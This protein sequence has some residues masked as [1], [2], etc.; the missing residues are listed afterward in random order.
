MN[1]YTTRVVS[2]VK[3]E[4]VAT[5]NQA[6]TKSN[7]TSVKL[8]NTLNTVEEKTN[9]FLKRLTVVSDMLLDLKTITGDVKNQI[10]IISSGAVLQKTDIE[11]S[12]NAIEVSKDTQTEIP[13]NHEKSVIR[14]ILPFY[15]KDQSG[16]Q[17]S[18]REVFKFNKN[19]SISFSRV[20]YSFSVVLVY[21]YKVFLNS[22]LLD[23]LNTYE[24][25]LP[26]LSSLK[27]LNEDGKEVQVL[28]NNLKSIDLNDKLRLDN[29]YNLTFETVYT[30]QLTIEFSNKSHNS[31]SITSIKSYLNT[32]KS[33]GE[34]IYGPFSTKSSILKASISSSSISDQTEISVSHDMSSWIK[35]DTT[36]S[37][38]L[39]QDKTKVVSFN[40]I[41]DR[42]FKTEEDVKKLYV[43]ISINPLQDTSLN[44]AYKTVKESNLSRTPSTLPKDKYTI[45]EKRERS[46]SYGV[47][48][49]LVASLDLVPTESIDSLG[50]RNQ[51]YSIGFV[52]TPFSCSVA[53]KEQ[54]AYKYVNK[55]LKVD[56]GIIDATYIDP[57]EFNI[58][59]MQILEVKDTY[60]NNSSQNLCIKSNVP[61]GMYK[62]VVGSKTLSLDLTSG[63]I[64][65]SLNL[66]VSVP[67]SDVKILNEINEV[68]FNIQKES[69]NKYTEDEVDYYYLDLSNYLFHTIVISG[70][71]HSVLYP[72]LP[73][74]TDE[75][76]LLNGSLVF[77]DSN[78]YE[79]DIFQ[80]A[81]KEVVYTTHLSYLN[82]N[83]LKREEDDSTTYNF[84]VVKDSRSIIK[85]N[86]VLIKNGSVVITNV[87][88]EDTEQYTPQLTPAVS[89]LNLG[90]D[91]ELVYLS[92]D[93]D[94]PEIYLEI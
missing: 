15:L 54:R 36:T 71:K 90:Q 34:I 42:S 40:T 79:V 85:L 91:Q 25:N 80:L 48:T 94:N 62:I 1:K 7:D 65:N 8:F 3:E 56:S 59:D 37:L 21:P 14:S 27:Y 6:T 53:N 39:S 31:L 26:V 5:V 23:F 84:T 86:H 93:T 2:D 28:V 52:D 74:N 19:F 83:Y 51:L 61:E 16:V 11:V 73:L 69:L 32:Y 60:R 13:F 18:Q 75:F 64:N 9:T 17:I 20:G 29:N 45:Y 88:T 4:L 10:N 43:K 41:N 72:S 76:S 81:K 57:K 58:Y 63:Y 49:N 87:A 67:Y 92:T 55:L 44:T 46:R 35:M 77:S 68:V 38:N 89:Y 66:V 82:G 22:L 78:E 24:G 33:N 47:Q 50:Y 12:S 70:M 30:D